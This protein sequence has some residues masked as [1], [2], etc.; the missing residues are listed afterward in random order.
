[1]ILLSLRRYTF[2]T[3]SPQGVA[4]S[5]LKRQSRGSRLRSGK[6]RGVEFLGANTDRV[7]NHQVY[8]SR[9]PSLASINHFR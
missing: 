5:L 7:I 3:V 6:V 2:P 4:A 8:G 9:L 1:V